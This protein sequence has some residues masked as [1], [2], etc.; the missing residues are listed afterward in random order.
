MSP[1]HSQIVWIIISLLR[2]NVNENSATA[3][4]HRSR[5]RLRRTVFYRA[6]FSI[7]VWKTHKATTS[8]FLL[9][10]KGRGAKDIG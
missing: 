2:M 6:K 1:S 7:V 4:K 9:G 8:I 5:K 3:Q 10:E